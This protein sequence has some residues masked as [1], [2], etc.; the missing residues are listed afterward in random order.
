[1]VMSF[2]SATFWAPCEIVPVYPDVVVIDP[3]VAESSAQSPVPF[4]S[5]FVR[6]AV[7]GARPA[8]APPLLVDQQL[9]LEKELP[10]GQPVSPPRQ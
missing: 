10:L 9:V 7:P 2:L 8:L 5:K 1:M 3:A 4:A 6:S